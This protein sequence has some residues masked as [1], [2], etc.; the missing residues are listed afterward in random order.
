MDTEPLY[1]EFDFP[2]AYGTG[3]IDQ[4]LAGS[5]AVVVTMAALVP[6]FANRIP[7]THRVLVVDSVEESALEALAAEARETTRVIGLDR[8]SVV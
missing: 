3:L 7:D 2:T 8:K 4:A 5:A 6:V 1:D